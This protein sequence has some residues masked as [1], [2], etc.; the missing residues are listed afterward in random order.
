MS[1]LPKQNYQYNREIPLPDGLINGQGLGAVS[2]MKFGLSDMG[3]SGCEVIAVYNALLLHERPAAFRELARYME[4]FRVLFGFWG[5][6][7]LALGHCLRRCGLPARRIWRRK[8]TEQALSA[9][10]TVVY[11]YWCGRRFLSSIHTVVLQAAGD[12]LSVYNAYNRCGHIYRAKQAAY[13][14]NKKMILGYIAE[15]QYNGNL[16]QGGQAGGNK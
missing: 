3:R 14:H 5:T 2:G 12:E 11:V 1:L 16:C 7:I 15:V 4:R 6:N 13:L 8:Q 9:G 10:H